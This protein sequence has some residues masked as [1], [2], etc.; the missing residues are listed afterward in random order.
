M[1]IDEIMKC[2][3]GWLDTDWRTKTQCL[4]WMKNIFKTEINEREL[5]DVFSKYCNDYIDGK[6]DSYLAH[7]TRG[8]K[9]TSDI[10]EIKKSI[11]DDESRM[12]ALSHRVYGVKR[13]LKNNN[14]IVLLPDQE[15]EMDAYE[16]I[17]K[18][19]ATNG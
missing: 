7:S 5:R 14:Q 11:A 16:I 4:N 18:M 3:H 1:T 9:L 8:Y 13:R 2:F 19:E 12:K 15:K 10:E 6:H 17:S